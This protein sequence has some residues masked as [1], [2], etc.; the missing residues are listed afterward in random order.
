VFSIST[1]KMRSFIL[2]AE[3]GKRRCIYS[4]SV[5]T[6]DQQ[7][8]IDRVQDELIYTCGQPLFPEGELVDTVVVRQGL[9]CCSPIEIVYYTG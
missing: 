2:C 4:G 8:S 3:C 6:V 7:V 9:S 1:A 5:L